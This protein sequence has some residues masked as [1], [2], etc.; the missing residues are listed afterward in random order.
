MKN[1]AHRKVKRE[2]KQY[3]YLIEHLKG[4]KTYKAIGEKYGESPRQVEYSINQGRGRLSAYGL[5]QNVPQAVQVLREWG[6]PLENTVEILLILL[7]HPDSN[8]LNVLTS[9]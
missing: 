7:S 6:S 2:N 1:K 9:Q 5:P 3:V 8:V 4:S